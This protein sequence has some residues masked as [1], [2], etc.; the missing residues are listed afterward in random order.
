MEYGCFRCVSKNSAEE[1]N[2]A[3]RERFGDVEKP[4]QSGFRNRN[5]AYVCPSCGHVCYTE[6]IFTPEDW[7]EECR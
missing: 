6:D 3:T 7:A 4:I 1:W 5:W 2:R